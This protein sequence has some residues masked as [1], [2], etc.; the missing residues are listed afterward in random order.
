MN[1]EEIVDVKERLIALPL[2]DRKNGEN[3][4]IGSA[5]L[6]LPGLF[7]TAKHL[8]EEYVKGH[9]KL[10]IARH[11]WEPRDLGVT[12]DVDVLV[13]LNDGLVTWRINK[14][15]LMLDCDLAI[16]VAVAYEG[17]GQTLIDR[18]VRVNIDLHLPRIGSQV[19]ALGYPN[20]QN[21]VIN[22]DEKTSLHRLR[23]TRALGVVE[24]IDR[25]DN[26]LTM[27][28]R[29]Q[30]NAAIEGG[31]SGGP[32]FNENGNLVAVSQ[33]GYT[34]T[35]EFPFHSSILAPLL[36]AIVCPI[37]LPLETNKGQYTKTSLLELA[38]SGT[39]QI[40]GLSHLTLDGDNYHWDDLNE[41]CEYCK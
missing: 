36:P 13:P 22:T 34:P 26:K 20:T 27:P 31:M 35:E 14:V 11:D 19:L 5:T 7:I 23:L 28:P 6:I 40:K 25:S 32:A 10:D 1:W 9:E 3:R 2:V 38:K 21:K 37:M 16:L 17:N 8:I 39:I 33:S 30:T 4:I 12:F 29:I 15:H 18:Q 41:K 24:A